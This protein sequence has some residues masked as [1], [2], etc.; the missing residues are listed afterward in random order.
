MRKRALQVLI[1]LFII[2]LVTLYI[3]RNR[4][5]ESGIE[6]TGTS[7]MGAKIEV[8]DLNLDVLD[9]SVRFKRLQVTNPEDGWRN[10]FELGPS[11]LDVASE[12]LFWNRYIINEFSIEDIRINTPRSTDGSIPGGQKSPALEVFQEARRNLMAELQQ[13]PVYDL[14][15]LINRDVKVDSVIAVLE[16]SVFDSVKVLQAGMDSTGRYWADR[17]PQLD[18]RPKLSEVQKILDPIQPG[19]IRS[20][21]KLLDTLARVKKARD[22]VVTLK[23]EVETAYKSIRQ[24]LAY[25]KGRILRVDDWAKADIERVKNKIGIPELKPSKIAEMLFGKASVERILGSIQY[26]QYARQSMPYIEKGRR[27]ILAGKVRKPPR[28]KGQN[29]IFPLENQLPK[30][31]IN[32]LFISGIS[33]NADTSL[34][35]RFSG[36]IK[37]LTSDPAVYG[38]PAMINLKGRATGGSIF[39]FN[40]VLDHSDKV[41]VDKFEFSAK[42]IRLGKVN[43]VDVA[44]LPNKLKLQKADVSLGFAMEGKQLD[45]SMEMVAPDFE[46]EFSDVSKGDPR[47]AKFIRDVFTGLSRLELQANVKGVLS[48]LDYRVSSNVDEALSGRIRS[49]VGKQIEQTQREIRERF[50]RIAEEQRQ[51]LL[52]VYNRKIEQVADRADEYKKLV[53]DSE[54][55]IQQKQKELEDRIEEEKKV[56]NQKLQKQVDSE[57]SKLEEKAREK[58]KDVFK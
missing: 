48:K 38:K 53:E 12:P 50:D 41:P 55:K 23:G 9:L 35:W 18:P 32:K 1:A 34:G 3:F 2:G 11:H 24:D 17:L 58:L 54:R 16:L 8:D 46:F 42:G 20:L 7:V 44:Y 10:L 27:V 4:L 22:T 57:K 5:V 37:G 40:G 39:E 14:T 45:L 51:K 36:G 28:G 33:S 15:R 19:E 56:L 26:V 49:L 21:E 52:T 47:V 6:S 31:L 43:L 13:T 30:W 29:I 25:N